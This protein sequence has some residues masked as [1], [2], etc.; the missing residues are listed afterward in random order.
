[1]EGK[2]NFYVGAALY[3]QFGSDTSLLKLLSGKPTPHLQSMLEGALAAL[4]EQPK[5]VLQDKQ[6]TKPEAE[7]MPQSNDAVLEAMRKEWQPLYQRMNYLRHQLDKQEGNGPEATETRK[8]LAFEI[9][10][11]EQ[12]CMRVWERRDYYQKHGSLPEVQQREVPV[13]TDPLE[14]GRMVETL[15]RNIR[16]NKAQAQ[17]HPDN[18]TYPALARQYQEQLEKITDQL[19]SN[20]GIKKQ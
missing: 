17:K 20:E 9:L 7:E 16:R 19:K 18:P 2:R 10:S 12:E 14:L 8:D 6:V 1:M 11:L 5:I 15:K 3:K 4:L 13:P